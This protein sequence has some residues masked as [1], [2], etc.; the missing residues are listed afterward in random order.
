ME[1]IESFVEEN[2]LVALLDEVAAVRSNQKPA[3]GLAEEEEDVEEDEWFQFLRSVNDTVS[4]A[5]QEGPIPAPSFNY[6]RAQR[7]AVSYVQDRTG[8]GGPYDGVPYGDIV[9]YVAHEMDADPNSVNQYLEAGSF[10][11]TDE[12]LVSALSF[13]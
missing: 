4:P 5:Y 8:V 2:G 1:S 6:L 11:E 12:G 9:E 7:L 13:D 3:G 10:E